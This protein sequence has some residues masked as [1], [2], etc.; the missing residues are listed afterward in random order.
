MPRYLVIDYSGC[1]CEGVLGKINLTGRLNKADWLPLSGCASSNQLKVLTDSSAFPGSQ[2]WGNSPEE[3]EACPGC[4][5]LWLSAAKIG[6]H[7]PLCPELR[8]V[9]FC[10]AFQAGQ[11]LPYPKGHRF[12]NLYLV[13]SC[14]WDKDRAGCAHHLS[15]QPGGRL[16]VPRGGLLE[17]WEWFMCVLL[18]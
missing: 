4:R 14:S 7:F 12:G 2:W 5:V 9:P 10:S 13:R 16:G 17:P 11:P 18:P 6:T 1:C 3:G 15:G 8:Q